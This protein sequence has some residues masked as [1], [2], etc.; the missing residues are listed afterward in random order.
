MRVATLIAC[1][2]LVAGCS[3]IGGGAALPSGSSD[4]TQAAAHSPDAS[5]YIT[6]YSFK[7]QD[8][9]GEP[10]DGL[11]NVKG[12]LYGTTSSYG[13]GYGTVFA[14]SPFGKLR[15]L[16]EFSGTSS[17]GAYP[18]AGLTWYNNLLYGTTSAG[19]AHGGGTIFTVTTGGAE[20]II[21][22]FGAAGDGSE[23][24]SRLAQVAGLLYGTTLNGGSHGRGIVYEIT[25][26]GQE[27]VLHSFAGAPND[28]GHPSAGLIHVG[29]WLYGTTRAG[30]KVKN[31]GSVFKMS[32]TGETKIVHAFGFARG[33]GEN[34]AGTLIYYNGLLYGTT[35]H[36]G[37]IGRGLG[38]V[39]EMTT[40]GSE[41]VIHSFG[42]GTD[43]AFPAANLIQAKGE[44]YGTTT[45]GG[46]SPH[47]SNQC[48]SSGV[49][50]DAG[51]YRCG[52]IFRIDRFGAEHIV[53]RFAG[54]P[55]GANPE[56]GLT[57]AGGVLYGTTFWGGQYDYY[58]TVF[59]LLP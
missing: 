42:A 25:G 46:D 57:D 54:D 33:D 13:S 11:I 44:L 7:G 3:R 50:R 35:L 59:R 16:H 19:G 4:G 55:D 21:H 2:V 34:P 31:G 36:G 47:H 48:I 5:G 45:G 26:S 56:S 58:G 30:G 17:D 1:C 39:F 15:I 28:G 12:T 40:A 23:P 9:G 14:I 22:S 8:A 51:Y 41:I 52:T 43:G 27:H 24:E 32:P 18:A 49:V 29:D 38:T 20:R 53:Y 6:L 37:T 10:Q